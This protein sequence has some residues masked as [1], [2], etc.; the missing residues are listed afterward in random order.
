[1]THSPQA[2]G[3]KS[4]HRSLVSPQR[5]LRSQRFGAGQVRDAAPRACRQDFRQRVGA[6]LRPVAPVVLSSASCLS[7]RRRLRAIAS[8]ARATRRAQAHWRGD[9]LPHATTSGASC[10]DSRAVG[11]RGSKPFPC[12][13]PPAYDSTPPA[14]TKKTA[15]SAAGTRDAS[16]AMRAGYEDLRTQALTGGRGPGFAIFL[17]HGMHEWIEVCSSCMAVTASPAPAPVPVEAATNSPP[18][19]PDVRSEIVSILASLL[20]TRRWE[21]TRD[22]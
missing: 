1:M 13:S 7:T 16:G 22:S 19:L 11:R 2:A 9:R 20:A 17:Q 14:A 15:L 18:L 3:L 21:A 12:S 4:H 6:R 8:Q 5:L 10:A